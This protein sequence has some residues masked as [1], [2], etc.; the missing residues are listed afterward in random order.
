MSARAL[1][2]R[3]LRTGVMELAARDPDLA[4]LARIHGP[5][6]LWARRPGF[7]TLVRIILE[8]QVSL[9][10]ARAMYERLSDRVD[11]VTPSGVARLGADGLRTLGFTRQ[12]ARYCHALA[13]AIVEGRL[14]LR[15]VARAP[16]DVG[17]AALL[18]VP[19]LGPW[20]VAIYYL[21][22][23][24]RPDIWPPG[25]L[26]LATALRRVKR[27]RAVPDRAR[28]DELSARWRPWRAVAAR[29]LWCHYLATPRGSRSAASQ[30]TVD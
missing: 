4:R 26:A 20:S 7:A 28:Q 23:L 6:P 29:L 22:A 17:Q 3:S 24:R 5:P 1:T 27:L 19:G 9:G 30:R 12:K 11:A 8:Q 13:S 25:D 2:H 10:S 14:D 15:A 18:A 16:D 21:M